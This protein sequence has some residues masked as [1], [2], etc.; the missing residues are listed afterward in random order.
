MKP[1]TS[2][3]FL[4]GILL[5]LL[6][7]AGLQADPLDTW[8]L[9]NPLPGSNSLLTVAFVNGVFLAGGESGTVL[10]SI[11][12]SDW[13]GRRLD[14]AA[15]VEGIAYGNGA[16]VAVTDNGPIFT[17]PDG[18]TWTSTPFQAPL[19]GICFGNGIFVAVGFGGVI[20]TSA[21]GYDW[22][23]QKNSENQNWLRAIAYGNGTFVASGYGF[24]GVGPINLTSPDGVNWSRTDLAHACAAINGLTFPSKAFS[25]SREQT[26][27]RVLSH[28]TSKDR[29]GAAG[30]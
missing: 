4:A 28:H 21:D 6:G 20:L 25:H 14:T 29:S 15:P 16:F 10:F 27:R 5:A 12:G 3:R 13:T 24:G 22:T 9:R 23:V 17:S 26:M 1:T 30:L 18:A 11:N 8:Q 2:I 7:R 19:T